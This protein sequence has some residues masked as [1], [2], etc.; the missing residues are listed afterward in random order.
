[1]VEIEDEDLEDFVVLERDPP[2]HGMAYLPY[3]ILLQV[4]AF[5]SVPQLANAGRVCKA[6]GAVAED[7]HL[8]KA[9][10][11]EAQQNHRV[12]NH[13]YA[14]GRNTRQKRKGIKAEKDISW[15]EYFRRKYG[16]KKAS[17]FDSLG[18]ESN[19]VVSLHLDNS[20]FYVN[21]E[22]QLLTGEIA[23]TIRHR[24][25]VHNGLF[26]WLQGLEST[27][28]TNSEHQR[29][30]NRRTL[31]EKY[32]ALKGSL[33]WTQRHEQ[34]EILEKGTYHMPFSVSVPHTTAAGEAL[35]TNFHRTEKGL[36]FSINY[37]AKAV[38]ALPWPH[39]NVWSSSCPLAF[40]L[41]PPAAA[42][43]LVL[44]S[45][46]HCQE[47]IHPFFLRG[48]QVLLRVTLDRKIFRMNEV[49]RV[50]IHVD[51]SESARPIQAIYAHMEERLTATQNQNGRSKTRA[52]RLEG[53]SRGKVFP[54][55]LAPGEVLDMEESFP[56]VPSSFKGGCSIFA[57]TL[58]QHEYLFV[59]RVHLPFP[60][61]DFGV[62]LPLLVMRP[63]VEDLNE[64][65]DEEEEEEEEVQD[66]EEDEEEGFEDNVNE[67]KD[68]TVSD[69]EAEFEYEDDG[70][71]EAEAQV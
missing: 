5:L 11:E 54:A 45:G 13:D 21:T 55:R 60:S 59:V 53:G 44:H 69:I 62:S 7:D 30:T 14:H 43:L 24:Q 37:E 48:G 19:V 56:L 22:G 40:H 47:V 26:L 1:M 67:K 71:E 52:F 20:N 70:D 41:S 29:S 15:K 66:E 18:L 49:M 50:S 27:Y 42:Q 16:K 35:P 33:E 10:H 63:L 46:I 64:R 34:Q 4:F 68:P 9:L 39:L 32:Y 12:E 8:W 36:R 61:F 25:I 57:P 51:N 17:L 38:L 23:V 65:E 31:F 3:E 28:E 6:W 58:M 2:F